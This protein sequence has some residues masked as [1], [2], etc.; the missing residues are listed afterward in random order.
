MSARLSPRRA[1]LWLLCAFLCGCAP[2]TGASL[3]GKRSA[4][5]ERYAGWNAVVLERRDPNPVTDSRVD[6]VVFIQGQPK[7]RYVRRLNADHVI[8]FGAKEARDTGTLTGDNMAQYRRIIEQ[9][10]LDLQPASGSVPGAVYCSLLPCYSFWEKAPGQELSL[11]LRDRAARK[12][13][14]AGFEERKFFPFVK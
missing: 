6:A 3:N 8:V 7:Y 10:K 4:G 2:V 13:N 12:D 1:V 9:E 14:T 11:E 5:L